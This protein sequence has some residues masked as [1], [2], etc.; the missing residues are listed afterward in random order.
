ML[1]NAA[2]GNRSQGHGH[3]GPPFEQ[4]ALEDWQAE[5]RPERDRRSAAPLPGFRPAM[6]RRGQGSIINIAS[7]SAHVP[8]SRVVAYSAA[9]AAVLNLTAFLAREWAPMACGSTPSLPDF[10]R[11]TES[12]LLFNED[13]SS[14]GAGPADLGAHADGPVWRANRGTCR[15]RCFPRQ[16]Q[17]QRFRDRSRYPC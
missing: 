9:K 1:V 4:V 16:R 6:V 5:F 8:L 13:G 10:F 2:G 17:G 3:A 11:G 12:R 7:V 14:D 15:S